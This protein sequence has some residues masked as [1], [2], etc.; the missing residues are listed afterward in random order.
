[1]NFIN[2]E[3]PKANWTTLL[4]LART[5][6]EKTQARKYVEL[7][8]FLQNDQQSEEGLYLGFE[9]APAATK[10]H[11]TQEGGLVQHLIEMWGLWVSLSDYWKKEGVIDDQRVLKAIINHDLHKA[12]RTYILD[13][14]RPWRT[15]YGRDVSDLILTRDTKSFWLLNS[16]GIA[17]DPVQLNA[18]LQAEGGYSEIR[19]DKVTLLARVCYIL[20]S[21]SGSVSGGLRKGEDYQ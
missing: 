4:E 20:D 16:H 7:L 5:Y 11:H 17:L 15:H 12:Y 13:G 19:T 21:G 3:N 8:K 2:P 10:R 18:L 14:E 9:R 1:V 6:I